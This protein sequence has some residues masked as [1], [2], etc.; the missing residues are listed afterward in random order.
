M[1][2]PEAIVVQVRFPNHM[3]QGSP[4]VLRYVIVVASAAIG[5]AAVILYATSLYGL[6]VTGDSSHYLWA[7]RSFASGAGLRMVRDVEFTVWPPLYPLSLVP[8][9]WAGVEAT[10]AAARNAVIFHG[11]GA[12]MLAAGVMKAARDSMG[13]GFLGGLLYVLSMPIVVNS[14][15]VW[16]EPLFMALLACFI[17][18][19]IF[20]FDRPTATR[21]AYLGAAA[22]LLP[23][24][25]YIGIISIPLFGCA[26]LLGMQTLNRRKIAKAGALTLLSA[27]PIGLWVLR[28]LLIKGT[29]TGHTLDSLHTPSLVATQ[30][31]QAFVRWLYPLPAILVPV[32]IAFAAY[33]IW[34]ASPRQR[35]TVIWLITL[36]LSYLI[37]LIYGALSTRVDR[38]S[39]RLADPLLVPLFAGFTIAIGATLNFSRHRWIA[40][41]S[42]LLLVPMIVQQ[43][44]ELNLRRVHGH[45]GYA[46]AKWD[47]SPSLQMARRLHA[48]GYSVII[49]DAAVMARIDLPLGAGSIM[50]LNDAD[51]M[52]EFARSIYDPDSVRIVWLADSSGNKSGWWRNLTEALDL[53]VVESFSDGTVYR[54]DKSTSAFDR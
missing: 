25:R 54:I 17:C 26:L 12:A 53:E 34:I 37:L 21:A 41:V 3:P 47:H 45:F 23:L 44:G 24:A 43:V 22:A 5:G 4:T 13:I 8:W 48:A 9:I 46:N 19:A 36:V 39:T 20:W 7:A 52:K 38:L 11:V 29:P 18:A 30:L 40:P 28:N 42:V 2:P 31:S 6:G 50:P 35:L 49:N 51:L 32:L 16:S 14:Q 10:H 15:A 27:L 1:E 33:G